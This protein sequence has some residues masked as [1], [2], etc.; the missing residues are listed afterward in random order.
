M[1][2]TEESLDLVDDGHKVVMFLKIQF[3]ESKTRKEF[4]E[5]CPPKSVYVTPTFTET[6]CSS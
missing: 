3:L 1:V 2:I 5:Q 6:A 4:F